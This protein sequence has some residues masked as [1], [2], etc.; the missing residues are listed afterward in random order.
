MD[1]ATSALDDE[2]EY[3][4]K[5]SIRNLPP[6]VTVIMITHNLKEEDIFD[7]VIRLGSPAESSATT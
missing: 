5:E 6:Y 4:V 3:E 7:Q 2:T 1:E